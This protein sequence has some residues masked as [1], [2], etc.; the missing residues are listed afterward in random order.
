M[1]GRTPD[2]IAT[3]AR[4]FRKRVRSGEWK[5]PTTGAAHGALQANLAVMPA[6][7]AEAFETFCHLNPRPCPLLGRTAPGRREI[8][9]LAHDLDIARD[10]PAYRVLRH[11][12]PAEKLDTLEPIWADQTVVF[13]IGCSF[14]FEAAMEG[15]GIP[16]RHWQRRANVPMYLSNI[17][18]KPSGPFGGKMVVSMRGVPADRASELQALCSRFPFAHGAPV[19]IGDPAEIG[20]TDIAK[21]DFGDDPY[22]EEG[23]VLAFWACGVTA[24][25]A[26]RHARLTLAAAHEPGHMLVTDLD[27]SA[28]G[29]AAW[30]AA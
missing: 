9:E 15:A 5:G 17:D 14:S 11:G 13:A 22:V 4:S 19:H 26:L 6:S 16:V 21:P 18:T 12:A 20:I 3:D 27:A 25:I 29:L 28:P 24:Q 1:A 8:P 7:H 10:V 30:A 2:E 23:D